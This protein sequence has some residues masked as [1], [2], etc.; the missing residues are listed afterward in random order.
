[1]KAQP[2]LVFTIKEM[3]EIDKYVHTFF[4]N[5]Q[6]GESTKSDIRDD[7]ILCYKYQVCVL[8]NPELH[9]KLL[10]GTSE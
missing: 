2:T 3:Q 4:Y 8:D 7:G 1:M 10:R 6:M 5:C 9:E